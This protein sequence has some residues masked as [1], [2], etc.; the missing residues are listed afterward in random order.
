MPHGEHVSGLLFVAFMFIGL[1]V[2]LAFDMPG[3]GVLIGMGG[4]FLTMGLVRVRG[5]QPVEISPVKVSKRLGSCFAVVVGVLFL[6]VGTLMLTHSAHLVYPYLP[7]I[8]FVLIGLGFI[9]WAIW[10]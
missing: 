4:G 5:V 7:V 10:G 2:G 9:A 6:A 8:A 1:G 3:P